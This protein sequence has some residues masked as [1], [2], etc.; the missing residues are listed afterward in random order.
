MNMPLGILLLTVLIA[1][2]VFAVLRDQKARVSEEDASP[3]QDRDQ[4]VSD[5]LT[6]I[7]SAGAVAQPSKLPKSTDVCVVSNESE[8]QRTYACGHEGS[9]TFRLNMYGIESAKFD[10]RER[11]PACWVARVEKYVARCALCG[12]PIFPGDGV[13]LYHESSPGLRRDIGTKIGDSFAGCMRWDCC[14]SG[15]FFAGHWTEEGF[16]SA[17]PDDRT[18]AGTAATTGKVVIPDV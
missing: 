9:A 11:C 18:A 7:A 14:P 2:V 1:L 6:V 5:G 16:R 15:G 12:L 10:Q 8:E 3:E 13:A 17:F 4:L